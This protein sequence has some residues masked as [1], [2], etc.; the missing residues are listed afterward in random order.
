[1]FDDSIYIS[2]CQ[3]LN[4]I[5]GEKLSAEDEE[6]VLAEFDNLESQV[7]VYKNQNCVL[8]SLLDKETHGD[9]CFA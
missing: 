8:L 2:E 4:A 5:L 1:M 6:D 7:W 3:E 9:V